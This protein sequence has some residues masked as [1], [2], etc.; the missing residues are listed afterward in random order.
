[1]RRRRRDRA[2]AG[3]W[4][5]LALLLILVFGVASVGGAEE[6]NGSETD[7]YSI[8]CDLPASVVDNLTLAVEVPAGLAYQPTSLS[9]SGAADLSS[10]SVSATGPL[11]G[12]CNLSLFLS[13]GTVNNSLDLDLLVEFVAV[14]ANIPENVDGRVLSDL[15]VT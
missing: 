2:G 9:A 8:A 12:T 1:M 6:G 14:V 13:F 4:S 11:D 10:A 3:G 15:L 7:V 5:P